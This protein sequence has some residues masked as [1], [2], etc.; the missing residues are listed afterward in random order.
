MSHAT[1]P[2]PAAAHAEPFARDLFIPRG[3]V[4][5]S[6]LW[7]FASWVTLF[8]LKP[9]VQ[10]QAA[11]YGPSIQV[12]F[13]LTGV[14]I[15]VAWPL[16]RL[17]ARPSAM[18]AGQAAI[19]A[20]S[21]FVL[22]QVVIWP[23]RLVTNWTLAR[24]IAVDTAIACAVMVTAA[25]LALTQGSASRR[26]RT[27]AMALAVGLVLLPGALDVARNAF[28]T[29]LG[30]LGS[31]QDLIDAASAP[32]LLSRFSEPS[33]IDPSDGDRVLLFRAISL[34]SACWAAVLAVHL[35][36]SGRPASGCT[37]G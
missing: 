36:R 22:L 5:L 19:D 17:S 4:L 23:L 26:A 9:P 24:A 14:G 28:G 30:W 31:A 10:P 37:A 13:A 21:V 15:A 6:S 7:V 33:T 11:S 25:L 32:A 34:A 27:L 3:L 35:V 29:D 1:E 2:L 16:L 20:I 8:G 18:P 12:L